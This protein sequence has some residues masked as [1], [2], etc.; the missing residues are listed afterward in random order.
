M[1]KRNEY[2]E[3]AIAEIISMEMLKQSI[4]NLHLYGHMSDEANRIIKS[5]MKV[6][7]DNF[8]ALIAEL[9]VRGH[10]GMDTDQLEKETRKEMMNVQKGQ[11][12]Y[13]LVEPKAPAPRPNAQ[14]SDDLVAD[15]EGQELADQLM[16]DM[17]QSVSDDVQG[18]GAAD[19]T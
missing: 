9:I 2:K 8:A 15:P 19:G 3:I 16:R 4:T 10:L 1:A 5:A 12:K 6:I 17:L 11:T 13:I 7:M 18:G 14:K